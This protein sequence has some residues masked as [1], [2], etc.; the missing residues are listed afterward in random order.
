LAEPLL[1]VAER[2]E[3]LPAY[4]QFHFTG[5]TAT[6]QQWINVLSAVAKENGYTFIFDVGTGAFLFYEKGDNILPLVKAKL[7]LK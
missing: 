1:R 5:H 3:Q 6:G 2:R 7:G 4:S